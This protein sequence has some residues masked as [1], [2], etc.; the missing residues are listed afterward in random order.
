M[1]VPHLCTVLRVLMLT[2]APWR[3]LDTQVPCHAILGRP[4]NKFV[5]AESPVQGK[6]SALSRGLPT[7]LVDQAKETRP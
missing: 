4:H 1:T 6:T 3:T 7:D 2:L 5:S